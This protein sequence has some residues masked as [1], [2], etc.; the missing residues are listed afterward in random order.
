M[1]QFLTDRVTTDGHFHKNNE[2]N[3]H[4]VLAIVFIA[5]AFEHFIGLDSHGQVQTNH[6]VRMLDPPFPSTPP[7]FVRDSLASQTMV[8]YNIVELCTLIHKVLAM[9]LILQT[10]VC[11]SY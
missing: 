3:C 5:A 10:Y 8:E 7:A 6:Y 4:D 2:C 1:G 11:T 9:Q